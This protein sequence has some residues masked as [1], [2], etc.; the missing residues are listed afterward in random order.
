MI[1]AVVLLVIGQRFRALGYLS[2]LVIALLW[3][4]MY[5]LFGDKRRRIYVDEYVPNRVDRIGI[6]L[7][8][9]FYTGLLIIFCLGQLFAP[10]EM[11]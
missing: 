7:L 6:F 9:A 4:F 10:E 3:H 1:V 11:R 5:L 2:L 8:A